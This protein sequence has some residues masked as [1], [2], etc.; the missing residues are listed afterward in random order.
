MLYKF[1]YCVIR[2]V[3]LFCF[4][5]R[6]FG[7]E[8]IPDSPFM[9][10][11]NHT[12]LTDP[13]MVA[14]AMTRRRRVYFMAKAE[15]FKV[16][17]FGPL[18]RGLGAFPVNRGK[19]DIGA[20]KRSLEILKHGRILGIFPEG[21]RV[22]NVAETEAKTGAAMIAVRAAVPVVP[23]CITSGRKRFLSRIDVIIGKPITM[24]EYRSQSQA[25]RYKSAADDILKR[26]Y[27]LESAGA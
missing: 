25:E 24:D 9:I 21:T 4:R 6:V 14:I 13:L 19:A 26:I 3:F 16:P 10:C 22:D 5:I 8:N 23:I 20:I 27:A 1:V 11:A 15:F 7:R 18:L 12:S 2:F 17:V